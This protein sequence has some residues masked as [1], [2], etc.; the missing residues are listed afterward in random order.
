MRYDEYWRER[1]DRPSTRARSERR[2]RLA[3]EV[4]EADGAR[5][6]SR[7]CDRPWSLVEVGC[8]PGVALDVFASAGYDAEGTDISDVALEAARARGLRVAKQ[9]IES[10]AEVG[11]SPVDVIVALE[12][13]EHIVDPLAALRSMARRLAPGGRLVVSLPNE[14]HLL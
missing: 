8:G 5:A 1:C 9:P 2:A 11:S 12:V 7:A 6:P 4:L 13:L 3:L 10:I 14:L